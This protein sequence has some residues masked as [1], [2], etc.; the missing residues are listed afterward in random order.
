MRFIAGN[1]EVLRL[2]QRKRKGRNWLFRSQFR[3][4]L[5]RKIIKIFLRIA[6]YPVYFAVTA[7]ELPID[8]T[9]IPIRH[10]FPGGRPFPA[11]VSESLQ[12]IFSTNY[13]G[14][15]A[16]ATLQVTQLYLYRTVDLG[17]LNTNSV[18]TPSVLMTSI[19]SPCAWMISFTMESPS[20][21]PRLSLPRERSVL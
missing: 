16:Y 4:Y 17:R 7:L 12:K 14:A 10:L 2:R 21:V 11:S 13:K 6:A 15:P 20:P 9:R 19:F 18:P 8:C 1:S 5:S 3:M